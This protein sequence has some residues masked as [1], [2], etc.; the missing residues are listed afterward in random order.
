[1]RWVLVDRIVSLSPGEGIE[2]VKNVAASEDV[3]ADHFPGCPVFPGS[4]VVEAMEQAAALLAG[5]S[6]GWTRAARVLRL[7]RARFRHPVRPG[8][9]LRVRLR[10]DDRAPDTWR[11]Q[12]EAR[13]DGRL[14][15]G[16]ALTLALEAEVGA[17]RR[18]R[19][20]QEELTRELPLGAAPRAPA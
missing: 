1:V 6:H 8:D 17:A 7:E 18:V 11:V 16:A 15:A 20:L 5:A 13:V 12:A 14:V 3:F 9:Q 10:V 4:L 19:A 2:V